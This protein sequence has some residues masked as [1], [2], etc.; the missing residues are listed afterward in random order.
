MHRIEN[1][2]LNYI[3]NPVHFLTDTIVSNSGLGPVE[4]FLTGGLTSSL[5][6]PVFRE[7]VFVCLQSLKILFHSE[8]FAHCFFSKSPVNLTS[9]Q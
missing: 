5:G 8:A 2:V 4:L 6:T 3:H 7:P 1:K 9:Q